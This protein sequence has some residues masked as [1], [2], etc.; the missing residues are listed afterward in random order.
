[1]SKFFTFFLYCVVVITTLQNLLLIAVP[2]AIWFTTRA[3]AL[4]LLP[5][6]ILIDGY[7]GAFYDLPLLSL[8]VGMWCVVAEMMKPRLRWQTDI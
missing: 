5:M 1:M 8:V 3:N 7:F 2:I 6:A 4:W